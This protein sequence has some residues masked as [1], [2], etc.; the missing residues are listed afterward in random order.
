MKLTPLRRNDDRMH[1]RRLVRLQAQFKDPGTGDIHAFVADL[2]ET[3]CRLDGV[4]SLEEG[5]QFL[6]KLPGLEA[7]ACRVAWVKRREAGCEFETPL[8]AGE[9]DEIRAQSGSRKAERSAHFG[10]RL[11]GLAGLGTGAGNGN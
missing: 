5:D 11:L 1:P 8:Y 9:C 4:D 2:S 10:R 6:I 3:G 7:K